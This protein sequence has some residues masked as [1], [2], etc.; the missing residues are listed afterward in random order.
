[1]GGGLERVFVY[2]TLRRGAARDARRFYS[3]AEFVAEARVRGRLFDFGPYPGLR[4][5]ARAGWVCGEIFA[6]TAEALAGLDDWEG[7]SPG[8]EDGEYRRVRVEVE[9]DG[10]EP[11]ASW[12][13]E[14]R[15]E[16]CSGRPV[17][18]SGDWLARGSGS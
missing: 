3:G 5:D 1:V 18:A 8:G 6:V 16:C 17:I 13:Y 11:E 14:A 4:L 12:V 2:G 7:V 10:G 15:E 9:R